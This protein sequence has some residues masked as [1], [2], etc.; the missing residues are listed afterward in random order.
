LRSVFFGL[1]FAPKKTGQAKRSIFERYF[2]ELG[3]NG[4]F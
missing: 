1:P 3:K 4:N 2:L